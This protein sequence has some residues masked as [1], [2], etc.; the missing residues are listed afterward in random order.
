MASVTD[1]DTDANLIAENSVNGEVV[2]LTAVGLDAGGAAVQ[3]SFGLV[4]DATG[5]AADLSG[6]FQIDATIGLVT[7][8]DGTQLN[9]VAQTSHTIWV[10]AINADGASTVTS[11]VITVGNVFEPVVITQSLTALADTFAARVNDHYTI[12]GLAGNDVITTH[13]G[14]DTIRSGAGIDTW[15]VAKALTAIPSA[16]PQKGFTPSTAVWAMT[17][18]WP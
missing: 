4:T 6:P 7:V 13:A 1:T 18:S 15:Q 17:R 5:T 12:S 14:N 9:H 16:A 8:R 2:G 3:V 10:K 11:F